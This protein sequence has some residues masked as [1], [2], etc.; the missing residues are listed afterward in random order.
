MTAKLSRGLPRLR[1]RAEYAALRA[2]FAAG[3]N[4]FGFRLVHYAVLNDHLR[5]RKYL[6]GDTLT[7]A[8]FATGVTLPYADKAKIPVA[9]YPEISRWHDRLNDLRYRLGDVAAA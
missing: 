2:A 9:D 1:Q 7:I 4:R 5:G 6:L 3:C 8:D